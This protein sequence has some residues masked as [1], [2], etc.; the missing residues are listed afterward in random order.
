MGDGV[1][2]S[3]RLFAE[4]RQS[5]LF[6]SRRKAIFGPPI[7]AAVAGSA[8]GQGHPGDAGGERLQ[9]NRGQSPGLAWPTAARR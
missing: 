1:I 5:N 9:R 6:R 8:G 7:S 3:A 4:K 2:G